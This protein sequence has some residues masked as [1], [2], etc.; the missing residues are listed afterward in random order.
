M[1]IARPAGAKGI[2]LFAT[3]LIPAGT[4]LLAEKPLFTVASESEAYAASRRLGSHDRKTFLGLV[5]GNARER[6]KRLWVEA[7]WHTVKEAVGDVLNIVRKRNGAKT[8]PR[9]ASYLTARSTFLSNNFA[10]STSPSMR[11]IFPNISRLNHACVPNAEANW[12]ANLDH[13]TVHTLSHVPEGE[14]LTLSYL[15]SHGAVA[16]DRQEALSGFMFECGC[17]A[18]AMRTPSS[19]QGETN[20]ADLQIK[21]RDFAQSDGSKGE[22]SIMRAMLELYEQ[23]GIRGRELATMYVATA[24]MA[25]SAGAVE[26]A[27][28]LAKRGLELEETCCGRD[29]PFFAKSLADVERLQLGDLDG[30]KASVFDTTESS[31]LAAAAS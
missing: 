16:A 26:N 13:F 11:A 19:R 6:S 7:G 30:D 14:E 12:N 1:F 2:G 28:A 31:N 21:V 27:R 20:R 29:S 10:L 17:A 24:E 5:G 25:R 18:C 22:L 23:E 9:A 3:Q 15:E 4:R 8:W